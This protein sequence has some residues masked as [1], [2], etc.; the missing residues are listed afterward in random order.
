VKTVGDKV[1]GRSLPNYPC[2]SDWWGD[3]SL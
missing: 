2:E 1:V 3:A